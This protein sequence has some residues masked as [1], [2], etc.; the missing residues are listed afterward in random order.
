M[1]YLTRALP[2]IVVVFLFSC[3]ANREVTTR[4]LRGEIKYLSSDPLRGRLTGSPGD[5]LAALFIKNKL[6]SYGLTPLAGDGFQ[7]FKVPEKALVGKENVLSVNGTTYTSEKDFMPMEFSSNSSLESEAL[8]VGYGFNINAD[9]LKWDDYKG[10]DP[11]GKWVIMLRA[12]PEPDN[13][14]SSFSQ[15][16]GD[17]D[18]AL[19]AKDMGAA[20]VL[21][22]SGPSFDQKDAFESLNA[23]GFSVDIPEIGRASCR[24]RV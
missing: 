13:T 18:K 14:R 8:F 15:F 16:S 6:A 1:T 24:E 22:V 7:R 23:I 19:I 9:S 21:M 4:V 5:S 17:R 2:I 12:D 10:I 3:R 20:G 11:K